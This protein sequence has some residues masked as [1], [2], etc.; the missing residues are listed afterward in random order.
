MR[1]MIL[2]LAALMATSAAAE[3]GP[4]HKSN[5]KKYGAYGERSERYHR[6]FTRREFDR[7]PIR[8]TKPDNARHYIYQDY[9]YWAAHAFQPKKWF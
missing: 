6:G 3:A 2:G 9:P 8:I 5:W 1:F 4:R 7:L